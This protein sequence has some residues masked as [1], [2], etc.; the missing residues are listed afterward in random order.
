MYQAKLELDVLQASD[1][2]RSAIGMLSADDPLLGALHL[3]GD[4]TTIQNDMTTLLGVNACDSPGLKRFQDNLSLFALS[5]RPK[6][7]AGEA[8]V[9]SVVL[10]PPGTLFEDQ[11][12][13]RLIED[14]VFEHSKTWVL[15]RYVRGSVSNVS[16]SSRDALG[17][18]ARIR[19]E[20]V[21]HGF[22]DRAAAR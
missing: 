14:L 6:R 22:S 4:L 9:S 2:F 12:Y 8:V 11:D 17:R 19:A 5:R 18:P 3:V 16:V 7:L 15:N 1:A 13:R 20:Y 10:P 21:Y